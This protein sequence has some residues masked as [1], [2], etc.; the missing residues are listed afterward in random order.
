MREVRNVRRER[1]VASSH[2][3]RSFRLQGHCEEPHQ[4][5]RSVRDAGQVGRRSGHNEE[6]KLRQLVEL[7][8]ALRARQEEPKCATHGNQA[9]HRAKLT[10]CQ[11]HR[12]SL[13]MDL[14]ISA[15]I[16]RTIIRYDEL[17]PLVKYGLTSRGV[18]TSLGS[19]LSAKS[20]SC[21]GTS[22]V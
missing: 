18:S 2:S 1:R 22:P 9:V 16:T 10:T 13:P 11:I 19:V 6:C 17:P 12:V 20:C 15:E 14:S 4:E 8:C 5:Y 7:T 21:F 3:G